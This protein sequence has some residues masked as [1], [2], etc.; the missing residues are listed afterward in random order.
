QRPCLAPNA[1]P[2]LA[3]GAEQ[4]ADAGPES[5]G[6]R[7][8]ER[9]ADAEAQDR[10]RPSR[11]D[12]AA[13]SR[14]TKTQE[15]STKPERSAEEG[16][17]TAFHGGQP[18]KRPSRR[19]TRTEQRERTPVALGC[20]ESSEIDKAEGD[21]G[22]R[23]GQHDVERLRVERVARGGGQAVGEVVDELHLARQGAL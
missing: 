19:A 9:Q 13:R 1:S 15:G 11:P 6:E 16:E 3:D 17:C 22:A 2:R 10:S 4:R 18:E 7:A 12:P 8:A 20:A 5:R 21:E 14:E 23:H